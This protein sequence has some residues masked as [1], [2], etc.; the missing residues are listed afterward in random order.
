MN[1]WLITG[2][3]SGLGKSLAKA[4]LEHGDQAIVTARNPE[5]V[6]QYREYFPQT[7]LPLQLDVTKEEEVISSI[8]RGIERFGK[9][10]CWSIMPVTACVALWKNVLLKKSES[11]LRQ[12]FS[13]LSA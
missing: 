11:S 3:S 13:A 9:L 5:T 10:M 7:A 8:A 12:T 1:T 6:Q 2:C 4:V